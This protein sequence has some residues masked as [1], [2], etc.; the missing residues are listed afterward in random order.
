MNCDLCEAPCA[1][2]L[3][4]CDNCGAALPT[5]C[6]AC[7]TMIPT[8][9]RTCGHCKASLST[10]PPRDSRA[11]P[12]LA[13]DE[14]RRQLTV[15]F[16]DIVDSTSLST[17]LDP[18]DLRDVLRS[19]HDTTSAVVRTFDGYVAQYLGDGLLA[20]FGYPTAHED[21]AV[22]A[23][24]AGQH[25]L[26]AVRSLNATHLKARGIELR[27][28]VGVHSG[29]V[30]VSA[31]GDDRLDR[32]A[33]GET[34]NVAARVE[35]AATPGRL[36]VTDSTR[37]LV[38]EHFL[39]R[40]AGAV[41]LKGIASPVELFE[42]L[43]DA[44]AHP[45][46]EPRSLT[47]FA[48]FVGRGAGVAE[49][50]ARWGDA[51]AGRGPVVWIS[52]EPGIG[53]SRHLRALLE[54]AAPE[55]AD[56]FECACT[57]GAEGTA[58]YPITELLHRRFQ[59]GHWAPF[60]EQ[61]VRLRE[62]LPA[63]EGSGAGHLPL[64]AALLSIPP[65]GLY[66]PGATT[67]QR[68]REATFEALLE[69]IAEQADRGPA[70]LAIEDMHWADPSTIELVG[71]LLARA[72]VPGLLTV[73]TSRPSF[74]PP[75][76]ASERFSEVVVDR[77]ARPVA[78]ELADRVAGGRALPAALVERILDRA[79]GV[80]LYVEQIT[81]S[82]LES[83]RVRVF[84][85]RV[86]VVEGVDRDVIP[87]TIHDS[88]MARLDRLGPGRALAQLAATVGRTFHYE[89]VRDLGLL[90]EE[91]LHRELARL[92]EAGLVRADPSAEG[93][94]SFRHV[95]FRD[96][97]YQSLLRSTRQRYHASILRVLADRQPDIEERRPELL[98]AHYEGAGLPGEAVDRYRR[99][100]QIATAKSAFREAEGHFRQA[101]RHLDTL[102]ESPERDR[103]EIEA[104]TGLGLAQISTQGFATK[105]VEAT[106]ARAA[107]LCA[108][109]SEVPFSVLVGVWSVVLVRGDREGVERVVGQ[110][111][112]VA[113]SSADPTVLLVAHAC[114]GS[115]AYY[116]GDYAEAKAHCGRAIAA[117]DGRDPLDVFRS[118]I[119]YGTEA[120]LYGHFYRALA[121]AATGDF[122]VARLTMREAFAIAESTGHPYILA[123][124]NGFGAVI[125]C[126]IGDAAGA[127]AMSE[128]AIALSAPNG[129]MF[130]LAA[131]R[132]LHGWASV[133]QGDAD[134]GLASIREG[135]GLLRAI[136]AM[137]VF[138][139]HCGY[140]AESLM[141]AGRVEEGLAAVDE[142]L[143]FAA[144]SLAGERTPA[145]LL[146]IK[147]ALLC[148]RGAVAEGRQMLRAAVARAVESGALAARRRAEAE[149]ERSADGATG[150][151]GGASGTGPAAQ[152]AVDAI[153]S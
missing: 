141:L 151:G 85:D 14:G 50:M 69:W 152:P 79:D 77:L 40:D 94:Y 108:K 25:I 66:E 137:V 153:A 8:G 90:D 56:A 126:E 20:Y 138:P 58:L 6:P 121:E 44:G 115:R 31:F 2:G 91:G 48:P 36:F 18:E 39:W 35:A 146:G 114:L 63:R 145:R 148:R 147:G 52:G 12:H 139:H 132:V 128:K 129:F 5:P 130:W 30:V 109:A 125:A 110:V 10:P 17:R 104:R 102:P 142:G 23:V 150:S 98:A 127:R 134:G 24:R 133:Q 54:L 11:P 78:A 106:Y 57:E 74:R 120:L 87:A 84:P 88:L 103:R 45:R 112:R 22:R 62:Q 42:L 140:F 93:V 7:G 19:C 111:R 60:E 43:G 67:P 136:G 71:R 113:E 51:V 21:D 49:L 76:P 83:D 64:F 75:W 26:E 73:L 119:A 131:G 4:A 70:V 107:E 82:M 123:T 92:V 117:L 122:E 89:L 37:R 124:A 144:T 46:R 34:P 100:G 55:V 28:R 149:L 105:D 99:A 96:A 1:P 81:R 61:F 41:P 29:P 32:I 68:Q 3:M 118:L 72:P 97:A 13:P 143:A 95:L 59:V 86:E 27:M 80:P 9:S 15:L 47:E 33:V 38:G 65:E 116:R 101:L 135:I 16:C 53:K